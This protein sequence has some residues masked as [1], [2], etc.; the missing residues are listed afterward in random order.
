MSDPERAAAGEHR[1]EAEAMARVLAPLVL[2]L[3]HVR[4]VGVLQGAVERRARADALDERAEAR[5]VVVAHEEAHEVGRLG[6]GDAHLGAVRRESPDR[7]PRGAGGAGSPSR[8]TA[9]GSA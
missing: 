2:E 3:A 8:P 6:V 1:H 5:A 7:G 4:V 9:P